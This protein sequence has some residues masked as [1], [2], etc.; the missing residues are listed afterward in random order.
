MVCV[1]NFVESPIGKSRLSNRK[2]YL[3]SFLLSLNRSFHSLQTSSPTVP[4]MS[5]TIDQKD[6][7]VKRSG[8]KLRIQKAAERKKSALG[9][10]WWNLVMDFPFFVW[11]LCTLNEVH[12]CLSWTKRPSGLPDNL[13]HDRLYLLESTS[14]LKCL[15]RRN[16][17]LAIRVSYTRI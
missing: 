15:C 5:I 12:N 16:T 1:V 13:N 17:G 11:F 6:F 3:M 4:T 2:C 8:S 9:P 14:T 7:P 10:C